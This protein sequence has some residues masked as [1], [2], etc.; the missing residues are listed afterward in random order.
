MSGSSH[1]THPLTWKGSWLLMSAMTCTHLGF[2]TFFRVAWLWYGHSF[3]SWTLFDLNDHFSLKGGSNALFFCNRPY[4]VW[5]ASVQKIIEHTA[6]FFLPW[7]C[8]PCPLRSSRRS[9]PPRG[10]ETL[11]WTREGPKNIFKITTGIHLWTMYLHETAMKSAF[12][13]EAIC[14]HK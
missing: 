1:S 8:S 14:N 2:C 3:L 7:W 12:W 9:C 5:Y 6:M 10:E 11:P 13:P 4:G